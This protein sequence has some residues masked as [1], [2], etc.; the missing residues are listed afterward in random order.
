MEKF[1]LRNEIEMGKMEEM[2][3][4]FYDMLEKKDADTSTARKE[5]FAALTEK[6]ENELNEEE[7]EFLKK[8]LL[9]KEEKKK[10]LAYA[11]S[12]RER[13]SYIN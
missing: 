9:T 12:K 3:L 5:V 1:P 4:E 6:H 2:V 10:E 7:M 8:A 13:R 11:G